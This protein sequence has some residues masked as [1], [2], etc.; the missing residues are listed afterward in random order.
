MLQKLFQP[1]VFRKEGVSL[2][3]ASDCFRSCYIPKMLIS[4]VSLRIFFFLTFFLL[5]V[6]SPS[7]ETFQSFDRFGFQKIT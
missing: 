2:A 6:F 7:I 5:D 4:P 1:T 3:I